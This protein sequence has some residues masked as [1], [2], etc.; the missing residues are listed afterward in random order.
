MRGFD[1]RNTEQ[2]C[3]WGGG[4]HKTT[5]TYKSLCTLSNCRDWMG[6][7][8]GIPDNCPG[9][10]WIPRTSSM[11]RMCN[12]LYLEMWL[13]CSTLYFQNNLWRRI[14]LVTLVVLGYSARLSCKCR[15]SHQPLW[16]SRALR[17]L[18]RCHNPTHFEM[19]GKHPDSK[20]HL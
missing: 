12:R 15:F 4:S 6:L 14:L 9:N 18:A 1:S 13:S 2:C 16:G 7:S 19:K 8:W 20:S 3:I 17:M 11:F 5:Y 10:I